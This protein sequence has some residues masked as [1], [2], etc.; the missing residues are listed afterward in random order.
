L[1]VR[2]VS[3]ASPDSIK[4]ILQVA[5][6]LG[7]TDIYVQVVVAGYAYYNSTILPRSQ[8]LAEVSGPHYDPLNALIKACKNKPLRIHAWVNALLVWS[9]REPPDSARHALYTHPEWF[10]H[11][12]NRQ[13]MSRYSHDEWSDLGL[14]GLYLNPALAE[15]QEHV[16]NICGEI[17][18]HYP[19]AGIHLDFI[20]YP[21][22]LWG[23]QENDTSFLFVGTEGYALRWL[24]LT[25]YPQLTFQ[26]RW[27]AWHN[28]KMNRQREKAIFHVV[29]GVRNAIQANRMDAKCLL[30][31]A[32]F[33]HPGVARYR[34]AQHWIGWKAMLD[35]PVVMSY[36]QDIFLF[37]DILKS[38]LSHRPDA[39]FG[40]GFLWP[41]MEDE[42]YWEVREVRKNHARGICFFDFTALDTMVDFGRLRTI[43]EIKPESFLTDTTRQAPINDVFAE[44]PDRILIERG[45][46]MLVLDEDIEFSEYVLSLSLDTEEDLMRMDL[47]R[48]TFQSRITE[49]V[50]AFKYL[51]SVLFPL[52]DN[53]IAPPRREVYYVFLPWGEQDSMAVIEKATK[54]QRL[55]QHTIVYPHAMDRLARAA[56]SAEENDRETIT[57]RTGVYVFEVRQ[58]HRGGRQVTRDSIDKELLPVYGNWTLREK[59]NKILYQ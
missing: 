29:Q 14:E 27:M 22:T 49:D 35:Y 48:D 41:D 7:I 39:I 13:S 37:S 10:V 9:L 55:T 25:R 54:V 34:F 18:G 47:S 26:L 11:D 30:T 20:R 51:D 45:K 28:W 15:V 6:A 4:R 44:L 8:Y 56:F 42:A 36:T 46:N 31:A 58:V 52:S 38:T 23:R 40:I 43:R 21:G 2:A 53:L 24:N 19:V 17:A 1:W 3:I 50:A 5:E 16:A 59:I 57:A 33:A 32:V 12:I